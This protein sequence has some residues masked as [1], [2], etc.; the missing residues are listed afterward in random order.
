MKMLHGRILRT[1]LFIV[2]SLVMI[3][4]ICTTGCAL[5]P[6]MTTPQ[7]TATPHMVNSGLAVLGGLKGAFTRKFGQPNT[8]QSIYT[9]STAN[10][11]RIVLTVGTLHNLVTGEVRVRTIILEPDD[12]VMWDA[13]TAKSLYQS[14]LP[15]D[16]VFTHNGSGTKGAS[17]TYLFYTSALLANTFPAQAFVDAAGKQLPPGTFE[18]VCNNKIMP[19]EG[20]ANGCGLTT[21]AWPVY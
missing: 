13:V 16:A 19:S 3:T 14:F 11:D 4:T 15:P 7:A 1:L 9:F 8:L 20:D 18:V 10:G 12:N 6:S 5:L 17:G 2:L 21:G